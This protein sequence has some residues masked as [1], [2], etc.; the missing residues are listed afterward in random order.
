[1]NYIKYSLSLITAFVLGGLIASNI[2]SVRAI[3]SFP[4]VRTG[5]YY[6]EAA[7]TMAE[8]GFITGYENGNFGPDDTLTRGQ[9]AV[10][11]N[12]MWQE[13]VR[14]GVVEPVG[15]TVSTSSRSISSSSSS[16][17]TSSSTSSTS[18]SNS[19]STSIA[20]S[21]NRFVFGVAE[22]NIIESTP[23]LT[24]SVSRIGGLDTTASVRYESDDGTAEKEKDFTNTTGTLTFKEGESNKNFTINLKEDELG[25]ETEMFYLKLVN[26]SS[27]YAIGSPDKITISIADNDGGPGNGTDEGGSTGPL[28]SAGKIQFSAAQ[29]G[30]PENKGQI[31]VRVVRTDGTSGEATV[32]YLT[33]GISANSSHFVTTNGTLTFA[34]GETEKTFTVAVK[35][36]SDPDGIKDVELFI[37]NPTGGAILGESRAI[38]TIIDDEIITSG[39]GT[40]RMVEDDIDIDESDGTIYV[41]IRRLHGTAVTATIEYETIA[42]SASSNSDFEFTSGTLTFY[43]GETVKLVP[44]KILTDND[45][46]QRESFF[47]RI[48]NPSNATLGTPRETVINID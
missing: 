18:S 9:G 41:G 23:R 19:S 37:K 42:S 26:P 32:E 33:K 1:M 34:S 27:G 43:P 39:S 45:S 48:K 5:T 44:V 31:L 24:L 47:L 12:R 40:F 13:L 16:S 4:D 29:Y 7:S 38:F 25:E 8:L 14:Q 10:I 11:M 28:T 35:D 15:T 6:K 22:L 30:I 17:T 20:T 36:N 2:E 46:E 3:I 21:G